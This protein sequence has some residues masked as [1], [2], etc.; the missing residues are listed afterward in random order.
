MNRIGLMLRVP[1]LDLGFN[2][3]ANREKAFRKFGVRDAMFR[4]P[5]GFWLS[6]LDEFILSGRLIE[7]YAPDPK[8]IT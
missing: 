8:E 1:S 5:H 6:L 4:E 3:T 7:V 2:A